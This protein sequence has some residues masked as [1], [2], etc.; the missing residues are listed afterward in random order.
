MLIRLWNRIVEKILREYRKKV[1]FAYT[2]RKAKNLEIL[3]KIYVR[4]PNVYVG[5]NV[6]LYPGVMFQGTGKIYIGNNTFIENN[7]IIYSEEGYTVNVGKNCMIA[8]MCHI[9]NTDHEMRKGKLMNTQGTHSADIDIED[10]VWLAS[11]VVVLKGSKIKQG[12]VIGAKAL[13]N[14]ET[15]TDGIYVGIPAHKIGE[16]S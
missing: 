10:D 6:T 16:R 1:F 9:I 14:S 5:E 12:T 8:G 11:Q 3:G 7:T 13:V 2:G 4:N 15:E